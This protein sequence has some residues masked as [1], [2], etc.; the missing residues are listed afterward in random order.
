M[1]AVSGDVQ[2]ERQEFKVRQWM[3]SI[4]PVGAVAVCVTSFGNNV[5]SAFTTEPW[6]SPVSKDLWRS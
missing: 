4:L 1:C 3:F 5:Q 6:L 2:V